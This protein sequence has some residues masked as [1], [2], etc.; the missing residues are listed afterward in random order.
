MAI[1]L[2]IFFIRKKFFTNNFFK[3][4]NIT[5]LIYIQIFTI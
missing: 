1:Y 5:F 4:Y 3:I 2:Y